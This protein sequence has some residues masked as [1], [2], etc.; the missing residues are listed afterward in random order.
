METNEWTELVGTVDEI[1]YTNE[2]NGYTVLRMETED[3]EQVNVTGCL[4]FS[5]PGEQL[6]VSGS[7]TRHP[8]HGQQFKA[9][10]AERRM[11]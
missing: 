1:I 6:I 9:E 10:Y 4:P 7:W 8:T 3:G 5:A 11:P 2:E